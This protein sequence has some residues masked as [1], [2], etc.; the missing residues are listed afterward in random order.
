MPGPLKE[1]SP[2]GCTYMDSRGKQMLSEDRQCWNR[3]GGSTVGLTG[4]LL[5]HPISTERTA[6]VPVT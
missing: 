4:H 1:G 5:Q 3:F 6:E 2:E